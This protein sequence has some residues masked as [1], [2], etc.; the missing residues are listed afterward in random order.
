MNMVDEASPI[1]KRNFRPLVTALGVLLGI[2][3]ALYWVD[4]RFPVFHDLILPVYIVLGVLALAAT[5][6]WGR[7]RGNDQR[8]HGDRRRTDR[9]T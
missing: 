5:L 2:A 6:R 8:R 4:H 7:L 1:G 9:R 3:A